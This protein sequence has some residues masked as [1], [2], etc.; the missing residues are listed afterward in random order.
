MAQLVTALRARNQQLGNAIPFQARLSGD[1]CNFIAGNLDF[2]AGSGPAE[3]KLAGL[4]P[5]GNGGK[6]IA[7]IWPKPQH[8]VMRA[9]LCERPR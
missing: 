9:A 1:N 3:I 8:A 7:D 2:L 4:C 5:T 6:N